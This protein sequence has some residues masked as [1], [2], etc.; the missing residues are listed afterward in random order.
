MG[1]DYISLNK[2]EDHNSISICLHIENEPV[3]SIGEKMSELN[4]CAY[5]N[6][7]NW[8]A[9]LNYYLKENY[10]HVCEGMQSDPEAGMYSADYELNSENEKKAGELYNI[11]V[12]LIENP[13]K[14]YSL[15]KNDPEEIEWD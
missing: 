10:P 6:G 14:L 9:L 13:E 12:D 7:Y 5:M 2:M 3:F 4:E 15:V 11:I 8:E 1:K